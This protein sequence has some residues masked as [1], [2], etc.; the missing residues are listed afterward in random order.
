MLP[1]LLLRLAPPIVDL[2]S[3]DAVVL[4]CFEIEEV[5][6]CAADIK[7]FIVFFSS[8]K[9]YSLSEKCEGICLRF[10]FGRTLKSCGSFLFD[11]E[12][13]RFLFHETLCLY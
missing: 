6:L 4:F 13:E 1:G 7:R 10:F 5:F 8:S 2:F 11:S 3:S 9:L 12:F